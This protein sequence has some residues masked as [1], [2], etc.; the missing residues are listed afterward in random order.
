MVFSNLL[1]AIWSILLGPAYQVRIPGPGGASVA[2]TEWTVS[3]SGGTT[4]LNN[5]TGCLGGRITIAGSPV[6]IK[7]LGRYMVSGN[8][9][10]HGLYI[11]DTFGST[12]LA[13]TSVNM[14]GGTPGTFVYGSITP[15]TASA[16]TAYQ[17]FSNELSGGDTRLDKPT[18]TV[19]A[20]ATV[21]QGF[22]Q[23]AGTC[24]MNGL[25]LGADTAGKLTVGLSFQY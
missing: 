18:A 16:S 1:V 6:V 19:T 23:S 21:T 9:G 15:F 17:L 13:S 20:V 3:E 14:T 7:T 24:G 22:F 11:Y 25:T 2:L 4:N 10:T 8:T 5:F 12:V